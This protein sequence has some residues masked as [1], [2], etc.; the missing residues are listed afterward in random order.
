[1][2]SSRRGTLRWNW[3][4]RLISLSVLVSVCAA[5]FPLPV[6]WQSRSVKDLSQPFPC[7][8]RPCGCRSAQQCWKKCCCFTNA[9]TV[10]WAKAHQVQP[11]QAVLAAARRESSKTERRAT[12][13]CR[14]VPPQAVPETPPPAAR[15]EGGRVIY[16]MTALAQQCQGQPWLWS[17]LP[18]AILPEVDVSPVCGCRPGEKLGLSSA[19][20]LVRGERPPVPPPRQLLSVKSAV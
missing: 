14:T 13:C 5:L 16:W 18:W 2:G 7:Q 11:P 17:T 8:N 20:L 6:G 3:Q 1:M 15:A 19:T 4:R 12:T 9:Q 10:A